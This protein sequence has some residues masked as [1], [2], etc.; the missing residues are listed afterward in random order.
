[1]T[2]LSAAATRMH[3]LILELDPLSDDCRLKLADLQ[4]QMD[5]AC[6]RQEITLNEWKELVDWATQLRDRC[7]GSGGGRVKHA[8]DASHNSDSIH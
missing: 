4:V 7:A 6:D 8:M 2:K 1:M 3:D 5:A